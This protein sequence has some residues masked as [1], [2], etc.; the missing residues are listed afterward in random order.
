VIGVDG[1]LEERA[2]DPE[3]VLDPVNTGLHQGFRKD[4]VELYVGRLFVGVGGQLCAS[5]QGERCKQAQ[6][7]QPL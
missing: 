3:I 4:C 7:R 2:F 6:R 1:K 5:G